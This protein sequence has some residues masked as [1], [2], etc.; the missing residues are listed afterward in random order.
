MSLAVAIK[1]MTHLCIS[2]LSQQKAGGNCGYKQI[3]CC[4][5]SF[6]VLFF[7]NRCL[8]KGVPSS[9]CTH[10]HTYVR[11]R[12]EWTASCYYKHVLSHHHHQ[13]LACKKEKQKQKIIYKI[14]IICCSCCVEKIPENNSCFSGHRICFFLLLSHTLNKIL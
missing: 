12:A 10:V 1:H 2:R 5:M 3:A 7:T 14:I 9:I 4:C 11:V 13:L 8:I 6:S